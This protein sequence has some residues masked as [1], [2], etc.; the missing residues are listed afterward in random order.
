MTAELVVVDDPAP[1]DL[2][3][4]V[5]G[6]STAGKTTTARSLG[7]RLGRPVAT[8]GEEESSGRTL[9]FDWLDH[10]G[11]RSDGR[12]IRTQVVAVPGHLPHLRARLLVTA[13]VVVFVADSTERGI[14]ASAKAFA[15]LRELLDALAD[16]APGLLV[17]ANKRDLADALSIDEVRQALGLDEAQLVIE[18]VATE[19]EGVRQS[20]VY[21][22]RLA[23]Q[24]ARARDG[25]RVAQRQRT[26]EALLAE[27]D[28]DPRPLHMVTR[29]VPVPV[30]SSETGPDPGS[31]PEMGPRP[32]PDPVS[33]LG[34]G[35]GHAPAPVPGQATVADNSG[36]PEHRR[37]EPEGPPSPVPPPVA[38]VPAAV[39]AAPVPAAAPVVATGPA[40]D[41]ASSP[42]PSRSPGPNP[43]STMR[44]RRPP[45]RRWLDR[46][47]GPSR[48]GR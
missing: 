5:D 12:A 11:G 2:R 19:G 8:T 37:D 24:H 6:P 9:L 41:A 10:T 30:P 43:T 29:P 3:V 46:R 16:P 26:A 15:E 1:I 22:V 44:D 21:A 31:G 27:L 39:V 4:V 18:T 32:E 36:S 45:W 40:D 13:D 42:A 35:C 33:E 20:F 23:L 17:Q 25:G 7:D 47:P 14:A 34:R 28:R 38:D 48:L